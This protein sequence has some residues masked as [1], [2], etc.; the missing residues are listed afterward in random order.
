M[1]QDFNK[2]YLLFICS[3]DT[4]KVFNDSDAF[5]NRK[6]SESTY[7]RQCSF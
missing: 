2:R 1:L 6:H 3:S 5:E 7:P 4:L